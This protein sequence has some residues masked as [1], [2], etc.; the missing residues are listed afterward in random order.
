MNYQSNLFRE[1]P[2]DTV[3]A[4]FDATLREA[5]VWPATLMEGGMFNTTYLVEYGAARKKA[6]LRLGPVN[7][8]LL[9][10]FEQNLMNAECYVYARCREIG[11]PCSTVLVC[12][13]SRQHIDRDFMIVEYI[14]SVVMAKATLTEDQRGSLNRKLGEYLTHLHRTTAGN[15][16]FASRICAGIHFSRWS[17]ALIFEV[18]EIS[19]QL[20]QAGGMTDAQ[21]RAL[22]RCYED[23]R[24]LLDEITTPH[25]LHTDLWE[26]N[27]LL[28]EDGKQ[29]AAIIDPDRAVFG[30]VDFEFASP[31][32]D[33][34][35]MLAGYGGI[36]QQ[37]LTLARSRRIVLYRMLYC[38]IEVYVGYCEY[39]NSDLYNQRMQ[40]LL[41]LLEANPV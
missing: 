16:G 2:F 10:G 28:T 30:D 34:P 38:L 6:V 13:T 4:I 9:M 23:N 14:P 32:M 25:L 12:D 5:P 24:T 27:V 17:D 21:A 37:P 31:W 3:S 18:G 26:G 19:A 8:H 36:M 7:R 35:A 41:T 33:N 40:Q 20:V 15:F 39:N 11:I 22:L 29:I 1:I